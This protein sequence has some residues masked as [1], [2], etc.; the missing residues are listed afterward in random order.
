VR[1]ACAA[2]L[3]LVAGCLE[4]PPSGEP[5]I[6]IDA[7][8]TPDATPCPAAADACVADP[9]SGHTYAAFSPHVSWDDAVDQCQNLGW[10][11]ATDRGEVESFLLQGLLPEPV[12]IGATDEAIDDDWRWVTG[13]P[14]DYT[15]WRSGEPNGEA[16]ANCLLANWQNVGW[17]DEDCATVWAYVCE[18]GPGE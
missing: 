1:A 12:W 10:Y 2:S 11:L 4:S 14:F 3:A 15:H 18:T 5:V 9:E 17:N 7:D 8:V 13:E 6:V 16:S